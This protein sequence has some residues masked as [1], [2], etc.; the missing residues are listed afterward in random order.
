MFW[1]LSFFPR[2]TLQNALFWNWRRSLPRDQQIRLDYWGTAGADAK[3]H[4]FQWADDLPEPP[5]TSHI[6]I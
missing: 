6:W 5:D 4:P 2:K 1:L 3:H